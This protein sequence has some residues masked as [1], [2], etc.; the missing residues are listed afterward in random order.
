MTGGGDSPIVRLMRLEHEIEAIDDIRDRVESL[1]A[2]L[3]E[4]RAATD[5]ELA[6]LRQ[7]THDLR[8]DAASHHRDLMGVL[9]DMLDDQRAA[10]RERFERVSRCLTVVEKT[11]QR[12]TT[13]RVLVILSVAILVSV[14]AGS[15][16]GVSLWDWLYVA[17]VE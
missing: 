17:P 5:K 3:R 6:L 4:H 7:E 13:P 12:L 14:M 16:I 11:L 10:N 1:Q 15:G 2:D 9:G 8:E